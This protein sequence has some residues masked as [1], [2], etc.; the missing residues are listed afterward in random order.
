MSANLVGA[1]GARRLPVG[2]IVVRI[3]GLETIAV[4]KQAS[5][6]AAG[7]AL[8]FTLVAEARPAQPSGLVEP[9]EIGTGVLV[10]DAV[11]GIFNQSCVARLGQSK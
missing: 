7:R 6:G 11:I 8:P 2:S 5:V 1:E 9:T 3:V 10:R 4:R